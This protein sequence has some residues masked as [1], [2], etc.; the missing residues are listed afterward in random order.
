MTQLSQ[1]LE[2]IISQ[3]FNDEINNLK[4]EIIVLK[5][6]KENK[7]TFSRYLKSYTVILPNHLLAI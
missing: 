3:K 6:N 2:V 7:F 4:S 5:S 1:T